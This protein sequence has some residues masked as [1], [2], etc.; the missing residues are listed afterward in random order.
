MFAS[1][2]QIDETLAESSIFS[3]MPFHDGAR[4]QILKNKPGLSSFKW[5]IYVLTKTQE[6]LKNL[7]NL[8]KS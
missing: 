3:D 6:K 2:L 7:N 8:Q 5:P 4:D 1:K